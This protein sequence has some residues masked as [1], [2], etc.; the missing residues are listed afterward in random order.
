[1]T[2]L[3][4]L[5][6]QYI[7]KAKETDALAP[8]AFG[9]EWDWEEYLAAHE[10]Q[11]QKAD[12]VVVELIHEIRKEKTEGKSYMLPFKGQ[13]EDCKFKNDHPWPPC[14]HT[15]WPHL[16]DVEKNAILSGVVECMVHDDGNGNG[17]EDALMKR[18]L[19]AGI[20]EYISFKDYKRNI[21]RAK[22]RRCVE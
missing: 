6:E 17:S 22:I 13:C 1:M 8:Q 19:Q 14:R 21:E 2:R 9:G 3:L 18:Y 12:E 16:R 20:E 11:L 7:V 5:I 10:A 15:V 4:R